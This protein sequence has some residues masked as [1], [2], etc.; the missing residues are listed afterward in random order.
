[1]FGVLEL[2]AD[3]VRS[4]RW[5]R[6]RCA[7]MTDAV[8]GEHL[9]DLQLTA[10]ATKARRAVQTVGADVATGAQYFDAHWQALA[11]CLRAT[12]KLGQ[13][14]PD[15]THAVQANDPRPT[16]FIRTGAP[17]HSCLARE[18]WSAA[19]GANLGRPP[20][21]TRPAGKAAINRCAFVPIT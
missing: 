2:A 13:L 19:A 14:G 18:V 17:G 7:V 21:A 3:S 6:S 12:N 5:R 4:V 11:L 9:K 16:R 15:G 1:M 8:G 10:P 20:S